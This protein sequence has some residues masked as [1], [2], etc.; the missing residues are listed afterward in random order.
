M[1]KALWAIAIILMILICIVFA[2]LTLLIFEI[3]QSQSQSQPPPQVIAN[4]PTPIPTITPRATHTIAP[5]AIRVTQ[6]P[7]A[8]PTPEPRPTDTPVPATP[9][10]LPP[11]ASFTPVL[12]QLTA[13]NNVNVRSGPGTAYPIV[14]G[15]G[16]GIPSRILGRNADSSWWQIQPPNGQVGW[17][18]NS[19]VQAE[20]IA[21]IP[22]AQAPPPPQPTATPT[23]AATA[24]PPKPAYQYEATGWFTDKNHGLTRFLGSITDNEGNPVD[25]LFIEAQCGS[26]RVLS[27]PS[28]PVALPP[29]Y[30]SSTWPPGFYDITVDSKPIPC[31][32][33]LTVV[34]S[35][36]GK[37]ASGKLSETME[38]DMT[39]DTSIVTANWRK[40]W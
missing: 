2:Q 35:A 8:S 28:G 4:L 14:G 33:L 9:T 7:P 32:W 6:A 26:Y 3:S 31:Q 13:P 5:T 12:P 1:Q 34:S 24:T 18:A 30:E 39:Y 20:N 17:V 19:V 29:F 23:L 37:T 25:G 16:A 27:N 40:N 11:T 21:N 10:T 38:I 15:L 36:D 22:V